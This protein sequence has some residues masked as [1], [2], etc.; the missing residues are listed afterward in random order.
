MLR[1]SLSLRLVLGLRTSFIA[2]IPLPLRW[3]RLLALPPGLLP[4]GEGPNVC[5]CLESDDPSIRKQ[6]LFEEILFLASRYERD[7]LAI[8]GM[9]KLHPGQQFGMLIEEIRVLG[10]V[11]RDVV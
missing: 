2:P 4:D 10:Q 1:H 9:G 11:L 7:R 5:G 3:C 6:D 8:V